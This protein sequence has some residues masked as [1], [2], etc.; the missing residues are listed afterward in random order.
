MCRHRW[1]VCSSRP[2]RRPPPSV[3]RIG[4]RVRPA[5]AGHRAG[6][7]FY[8]NGDLSRRAGYGAGPTPHPEG[9]EGDRTRLRA[10]TRVTPQADPPLPRSTPANRSTPPLRS[11]PANRS[12]PQTAP[13]AAVTAMPSAPVE[14]IG[15]QLRLRA[16]ATMAK[17][18]PTVRRPAVP[19]GTEPVESIQPAVLNPR[20]LLLVAGCL[21]AVVAI[22]VGI[23]LGGGTGGRTPSGLPTVT[24][25]PD[26]SF[27]SELIAPTVVSSYNAKTKI[28]R[29]DWT[30]PAA[31][32]NVAFC[33]GSGPL[34]TARPERPPTFIRS[35]RMPRRQYAFPCRQS[36]SMAAPL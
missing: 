19:V 29:F 28:L 35:R 10:P 18:E 27:G 9:G 21:V 8:P 2:C 14:S 13:R 15:G 34:R 24:D 1:S 25:T 4:A 16:P 6:T 12:T 32:K 26:T 11:T 7:A 5:A 22:G 3:R 33:G 20:R 31:E 23:A 17:S 30:V 36:R